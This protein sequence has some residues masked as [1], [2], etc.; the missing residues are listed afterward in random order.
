MISTETVPPSEGFTLLRQLPV[1]FPRN[2]SMLVG[3]ACGGMPAQ[4]AVMIASV[5]ARSTITAFNFIARLL[6]AVPTHITAPR[7]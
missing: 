1:Q 7:R 5:T 4:L 6:I 2:G 3:R